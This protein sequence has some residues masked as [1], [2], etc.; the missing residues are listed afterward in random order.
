MFSLP[1]G[2]CKQIPPIIWILHAGRLGVLRAGREFPL[3]DGFHV[4]DVNCQRA[5]IH[6]SHVGRFLPYGI[7]FFVCYSSPKSWLGIAQRFFSGAFGS[8]LFSLLVLLRLWFRI[9]SLILPHLLF[10]RLPHVF[11]VVGKNPQFVR[12]SSIFYLC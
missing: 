1:V 10:F 9:D 4:S 7:S 3:V 2:P 12:P 5:D 8:D 6:R 11:V